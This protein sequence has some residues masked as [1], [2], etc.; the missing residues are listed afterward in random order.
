MS[1][2]VNLSI[3]ARRISDD[4]PTS[5]TSGVSKLCECN[6]R[7]SAARST[8]VRLRPERTLH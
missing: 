2:T 4:E 7:P 3:F 6:I 1:G 5:G 8:D